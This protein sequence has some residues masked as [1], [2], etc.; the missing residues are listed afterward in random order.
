MRIGRFVQAA[1]LLGV[2]VFAMAPSARA[3]VTFNT[4]AAGTGFSLIGLTLSSFSGV[5]ATLTFI[6]DANTTVGVPSNVNFGNF[7]LVCPSCSTQA[8]GTGSVFS[9][10][11]FNLI[12]TD[13]TDGSATGKFVGT[14]AGGTVYSDVS[15]LTISW[16]PLILGPGTTN[17]TTGNF[18]PTS[19]TT[20][21]FTGIVAPNSGEV[22]GQST[23][24]GFVNSTAVPEPATLSMIGGAL[25]GLGLWRRKGLS[26]Q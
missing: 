16:S 6:P 23:I 19:F 17:A 15:P 3:T 7:T 24:Q 2:A 10:F 25:L 4:D 12:I 1:S 11:T 21:S 20:T 9:A 26:R 18:G 14:S 5:S 8:I 13:V 22:H